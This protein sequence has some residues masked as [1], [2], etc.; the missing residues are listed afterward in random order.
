MEQ[1]ARYILEQVGR[2]YRRYGIKSVTMDDVARELG[3]SKKTL[4]EHFRDKEDLV[5]RVLMNEFDRHRCVLEENMAQRQQNAIE[6]LFEVYKMTNAMLRDFNPSMGYDLRKYYPRLF[7][8][9]R[10]L[11]RKRVLESVRD[12]L[13]RGKKEG[14]YRKE[15]NSALIA[16]LHVARAESMLDNDLFT[17][18]EIASMKLFHEVFVY[19]LHGIL[20]HKG[21]IFFERNFDQFKSTL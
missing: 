11:W 12:N 21:R 2:L 3:I 19:H 8:R 20:S 1:K 9:I 10:D 14:L 13:T 7:I 6:S 17:P 15:L 16:K 4:Y 5:R 18:E